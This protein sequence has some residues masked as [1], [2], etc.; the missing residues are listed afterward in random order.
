MP[1]FFHAKNAILHENIWIIIRIFS[2][3]SSL[4]IEGSGLL[5]LQVCVRQETQFKLLVK[6]RIELN[7][8]V[9]PI[10]TTTYS[11]CHVLTIHTGAIHSKV[12]GH[13]DI[14]LH[15]QGLGLSCTTVL[16]HF[17]KCL[18]DGVEGNLINILGDD[19]L[20]G[21]GCTKPTRKRSPKFGVATAKSAGGFLHGKFE[22]AVGVATALAIFVCLLDSAARMHCATS[23][24]F[25][26]AG[27]PKMH[28]QHRINNLHFIFSAIACTSREDIH[29]F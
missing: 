18:L 15:C 7:T 27:T 13:H 23:I 14:Y 10:F 6:E 25:K 29:S 21:N 20:G 3:F 19:E 8:C 16:L 28:F 11:A 12:I 22:G 4:R 5:L 9:P 24:G 2:V 17:I 1:N 26:I